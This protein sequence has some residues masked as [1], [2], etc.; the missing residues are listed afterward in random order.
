MRRGLL[1][2]IA[3]L[4]HIYLANHPRGPSLRGM[5]AHTML[6]PHETPTPHPAKMIN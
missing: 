4:A 3:L 6:V 1:A 2:L 5:R